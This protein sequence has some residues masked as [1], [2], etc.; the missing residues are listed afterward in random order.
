MI[1]LF[2]NTEV[3]R[4][5]TN[6][7]ELKDVSLEVLD[8]ELVTATLEEDEVIVKAKNKNGET[9]LI[10]SAVNAKEEVKIKII[11]EYANIRVNLEKNN[12]IGFRNQKLYI[13]VLNYDDLVNINFSWNS[14]RDD[15][16]YGIDELKK[17]LYIKV[18]DT[19]MEN[20]T[21]VFFV[22]AENAEVLQPI[23][24]TVAEIKPDQII[25]INTDD[26]KLER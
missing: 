26:I 1:K 22:N 20:E 21:S 14:G 12:L 5:I 10:I 11:V 7:Q 19:A 17:S 4:Q 18:K 23:T 24:I 15:F 9:E 13:K 6:F 2:A 25:E 3:R 16:I 8:E